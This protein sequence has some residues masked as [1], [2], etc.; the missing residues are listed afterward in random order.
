MTLK[1]ANVLVILGKLGGPLLKVFLKALKATKVVK[2]GLVGASMIAYSYMFTWQ[3]ALII[4]GFLFIHEY[5]HIWAMKRCSVKTKGIYFIPFLGAAAVSDAEFPTYQSEV[6]IALMGPLVGL[7]PAFFFSIV[8]MITHINFFGGAALWMFTVTAFS[9]L[10]VMPLDG[11][12]VFRCVA[13]SISS[14]GGMA[15][16]AG[17]IVL[18]CFLSK[19]IGLGLVLFCMIIGGIGVIGEYIG[20]KQARKKMLKDINKIAES[21]VKTRGRYPEIGKSIKKQEEIRVDV[22]SQKDPEEYVRGILITLSKAKMKI[23][24]K[25]KAIFA[26][27]AGFSTIA[28]LSIKLVFI[29][30]SI[31]GA[32][33]AL[34][35]LTK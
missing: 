7:I 12:R 11:G 19:Y 6:F 18:L 29:F 33:L 13:L 9:L 27:F 25:G 3:F 23:P 20:A 26:S 24:M 14:W 34:N 8:F 22:F 15:I 10:P 4:L 17:G 21:Y 2:V 5:G 32:E 1:G 16:Y 30:K 28:V 35:L 31:P